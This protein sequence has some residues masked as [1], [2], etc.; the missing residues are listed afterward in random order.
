VELWEAETQMKGGIHMVV[1]QLILS[2]N[3]TRTGASCQILTADMRLMHAGII[4]MMEGR[5]IVHSCGNSTT[6]SSGVRLPELIGSARIERRR[7]DGQPTA[8][9]LSEKIMD[10]VV[11]I[12]VCVPLNK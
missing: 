6:V 8:D 3:F 11:D 10:Q 4:S 1:I 9:G 2:I 5:C 12:K 7:H